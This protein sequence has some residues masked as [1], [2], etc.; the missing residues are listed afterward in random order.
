MN[1]KIV[2]ISI[3][4][5]TLIIL[6]GIIY[7]FWQKDKRTNEDSSVPLTECEKL[8]AKEGEKYAICCQ[9]E[10]EIKICNDKKNFSKGEHLQ[11]S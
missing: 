5:I 4:I 7:W 1:R 11:I 3:V 10:G 9:E 2:L 8:L 6:G